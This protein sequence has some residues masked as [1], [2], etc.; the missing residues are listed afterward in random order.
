MRN[1]PTRR[2]RPIS[3]QRSLTCLGGRIQIYLN[4]GYGFRFC[5]DQRTILVMNASLNSMTTNKN[6]R[7]SIGIRSKCNLTK[8][9]SIRPKCIS[10]VPMI[11]F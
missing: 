8:L 10:L 11:T 4:Q 2:S 6:S 3:V 7:I 5:K 9:V 1:G